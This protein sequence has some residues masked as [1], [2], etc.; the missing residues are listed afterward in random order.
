MWREPGFWQAERSL[1]G[2]LLAPAGWAYGRAVAWRFARSRPFRAGVPVICVGNPVLGGGGKTPTAI[3]VAR[4]L[5]GLGRRPHFLTR[6]YGGR[7]QGPVTVGGGHGPGDVGDEALLLAAHAPTHVAADRPA[8]AAHA[9]A[10]GADAIVMDDGFQNPT[11]A[12]DLGLLVVD[13]AAGV[14]NGKVFPAGPLREPLAAQLARAEALAVIG[15]GARGATVAEAARAAGVLVLG[16]RLVPAAGAPDL[17]G[18]ALVAFCG[19]ARPEKFRRTLEAAGARIAEALIFADHHAFSPHDVAR[20][21]AAAERHR[22]RPVTTEKDAV[23]LTEDADPGG[24][25][26]ARLAVYPVETAFDDPD[27]VAGLLQAALDRPRPQT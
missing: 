17:A 11:I 7:L 2:R 23:R 13:G 3:A 8:G 12:K 27:A 16:A 18:A 21:L 25:L 15:A 6:G 1:A 24:R 9:V 19:I 22:A 4:L 20:I 14:G 5:A 26:R 10:A